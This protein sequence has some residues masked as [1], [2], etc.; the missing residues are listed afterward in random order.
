MNNKYEKLV[1]DDTAYVTTLTEKY[2][3]RKR[4]ETPDPKKIHAFIP[5]TIKEIFVKR[6]QTVRKG[7]MLLIFEAM[8]MSN[9]ITAPFDG[10]IKNVNVKPGDMVP[11]SVLLLEF[12]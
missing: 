3:R 2:S 4:Y 11:K 6:G 8:K 5:G 10:R 7:D 9:T 12:E 1:I